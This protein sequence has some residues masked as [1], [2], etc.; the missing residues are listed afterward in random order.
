MCHSIFDLILACWKWRISFR[1]AN[2]YAVNVI[3]FNDHRRNWNEIM[4]HNSNS[5]NSIVLKLNHIRSSTS[6]VQY[7]SICHFIVYYSIVFILNAICNIWNAPFVVYYKNRFGSVYEWHVSRLYDIIFVC[8]LWTPRDS[9]VPVTFSLWWFVI[10]CSWLIGFVRHFHVVSSPQRICYCCRCD[11]T[12]EF[13]FNFIFDEKV[14]VFHTLIVIGFVSMLVIEYA[15]CYL[16]YTKPFE[17]LMV[18]CMVCQRIIITMSKFSFFLLCIHAEAIT[19]FA[20]RLAN[21]QSHEKFWFFSM[22]SFIA[23]SEVPF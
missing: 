14:Q 5:L 3:W 10:V 2:F 8:I 12:I 4:I 19:K 20:N 18:K 22:S 13:E 23:V 21:A 1:W 9:L 17:W 16:T 7:S 11:I 15:C 6:I